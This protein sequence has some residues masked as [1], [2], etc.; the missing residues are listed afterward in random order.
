MHEAKLQHLQK[1]GTHAPVSSEALVGLRSLFVRVLVSEQGERSCTVDVPYDNHARSQ[2]AAPAE[3]RNT[4]QSICA[5]HIRVELARQL[6][7]SHSIAGHGVSTRKCMP[8][9]IAQALK[10]MRAT[11]FLKAQP[12]GQR[13]AVHRRSMKQGA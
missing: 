6:H 7:S 4:Q 13:Q 11:R 3:C 10:C 8:Q 2:A 9:K 5:S 1:S 12:E